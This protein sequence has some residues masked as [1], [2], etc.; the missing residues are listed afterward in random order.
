M[1]IE[2]P[3]QEELDQTN[4]FRTYYNYVCSIAGFLPEKKQDSSSFMR[5]V[6]SSHSFNGI[7]ERKSFDCKRLEK[8]FRNAWFTEIQLGI[9]RQ[10]EEFAIYSNHWAPVQL[11]YCLYLAI[12]CLFI[13]MGREDTGGEHSANLSAITNEIKLRPDLFPYPWRILCIGDPEK[14]EESYLSLPTEV[15]I[16]RISSLTAYSKITFWDSFALFLKTTRERQVEKKCE[17][18]KRKNKKKRINPKIKKDLI[19]NLGPT[20]FFHAIYRLRLRSNYEDADSFLLGLQGDFDAIEFNRSIRKINWF[21]LLFLELITAKYIGKKNF[22]GIV[23]R[24]NLR[25]NSD[26]N[27]KAA[28]NAVKVRWGILSSIWE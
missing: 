4:R 12:R 23:G 20:S 15:K 2:V 7:Q 8:L 6:V 10:Q 24:F 9:T 18:W 21:S 1:I 14:K 19:D 27:A 3:S 16:Q 13:A 5:G 22:H 11:Y 25:K 17:G 28:D 26:D